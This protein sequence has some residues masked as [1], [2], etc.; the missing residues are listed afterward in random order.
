MNTPVEGEPP[1]ELSTEELKSLLI[2]NWLT[3]DAMWFAGSVEE[4]GIEAANRLNR[5]AV[6]GMSTVEALRILK[7]TGL[8]GVRTI[9]DLRRFVDT[10]VNLVIPSAIEF[11]I[12]WDLDGSSMSFEVTRCFAFEGV[13]ALGVAGTYECGIFER[14]TG[15]LGALGVQHEMV[16]DEVL[17]TMH[18]HGW[19]RRRFL[20]EFPSL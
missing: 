16:P 8:D 2:R 10:A 11:A 1:I 7:A 5:R 4:L 17:C 6:R 18:H 20:L 15:W 12:E 13:T 14:V 9:G 3:H 19:C